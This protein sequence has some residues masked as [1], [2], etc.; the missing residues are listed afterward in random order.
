MVSAE[1]LALLGFGL[2]LAYEMIVETPSN[3]SVATGSMVY[4]LVL[5]LGIAAIAIF[6]WRGRRWVYGP[7]VFLQLLA[8]PI[9]YYMLVGGFVFGAVL[10][11]GVAVTGLVALLSP[12]GR[13]AFG[14]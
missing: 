12:E 14:R 6:A 9:A 13:S 2:W 3:R 7:T 8:L 10:V 11:A 4:F 5:G 1:A